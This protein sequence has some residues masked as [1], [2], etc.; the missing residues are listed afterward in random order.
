MYVLFGLL[1]LDRYFNF[2]FG[3]EFYFLIVV[4]FFLGVMLLRLLVKFDMVLFFMVL[5]WLIS[6]ELIFKYFLFIR[7]IILDIIGFVVFIVG[8]DFFLFLINF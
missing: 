3:S 7:M 1:V 5:G 4:L 8:V 6:L 2:L